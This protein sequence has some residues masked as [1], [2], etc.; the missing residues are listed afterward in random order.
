MKCPRGGGG[1]A[2]LTTVFLLLLPVFLISASRTPEGQ[3]FLW[4]IGQASVLHTETQSL[5]AMLR[6]DPSIGFVVSR[7]P[8]LK[9]VFA[10]ESALPE[11]VICFR[12]TKGCAGNSLPSWLRILGWSGWKSRLEGSVVVADVVDETSHSKAAKNNVNLLSDES[13]SIATALNA[14]FMP[15]AYG[16]AHGQL[17]WKQRTPRQAPAEVLEQFLSTVGDRAEAQTLIR[18]CLAAT[19]EAQSQGPCTEGEAS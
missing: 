6:Q 1:A 17:V 8:V 7:N 16:F 9:P 2:R 14:A 18:S 13:R 15:R 3:Y 11:L 5:E 19:G 10:P 4:S 12:S